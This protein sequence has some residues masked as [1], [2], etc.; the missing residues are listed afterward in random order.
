MSG[1]IGG[2]ST[3]LVDPAAKDKSRPISLKDMLFVAPY[4]MQVN[5]LRETLGEDARV[6]TVDLFQGQEA[7]ILILSMC[8]SSAEG[9]PRGLD[10][11]FNRNRMNVAISRAKS[12]ALV[13]GSPE[14]KETACSTVDKMSLVNLFC[15]VV[16]IGSASTGDLQ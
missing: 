4:N 15:K 9:S 3:R 5:K 16:R 1:R 8:S 12:L 13:V 7:P 14:L 2:N 11:L 6:G 10:F